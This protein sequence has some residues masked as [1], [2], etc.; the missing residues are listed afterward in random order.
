M[1]H[2]NVRVNFRNSKPQVNKRAN[3]FQ[4]LKFWLEYGHLMNLKVH[5]V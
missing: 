4:T 2:L 1:N 5:D 3:N